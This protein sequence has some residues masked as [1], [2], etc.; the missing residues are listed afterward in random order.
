VTRHPLERIIVAVLAC[1]LLVGAMDST[2][3]FASLRRVARA[4]TGQTATAPKGT[5]R[6]RAALITVRRPVVVRANGD[7]PAIDAILP[8]RVR[9]SLPA[10]AP[11][12]HAEPR[13]TSS[14]PTDRNGS[15]PPLRC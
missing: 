7:G 2:P 6:A 10:L 11:L 14:R 8:P 4:A 1:L 12:A 15:G 3:R 9:T 13:F 5:P